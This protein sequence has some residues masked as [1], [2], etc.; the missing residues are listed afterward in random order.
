MMTL[1][2]NVLPVVLGFL[3]KLTAIKTQLAADN[4]KLMVEALMVRSDSI[5]QARE[6]ARKE[7]PYSAL[8]RRVFIF[9]VLGM[10]VFMVVAPVFLQ[11]DT[12]I[13]IIKKGFSFLGIS[14]TPDKTEFVTVKGMLLMEEVRVVFVMIAEMF[15]GSTLAVSASRK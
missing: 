4:Q 8:T 14:I 13:P 6:A 5:N 12:V 11:V 2:T 3:A 10:V 7:S 1:L 9:V 15:F